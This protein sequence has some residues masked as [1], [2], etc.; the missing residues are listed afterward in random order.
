MRRL[1]IKILPVVMLLTMSSC[2]LFKF[3]VSVGDK[4]MTET[5]FNTR[6]MVRGFYGE[7]T[8]GVISAADSIYKYSDDIDHKINAL[9]WKMQST[10]ACADAAYSGVPEVSLL[11]T[12]VLCCRMQELMQSQPDSLLF[13]R[14]TKIAQTTSGYLLTRIEGVAKRYLSADRFQQ[15]KSFVNTY[16]TSHPMNDLNFVRINLLLDWAENQNTEDKN[17]VKSTGSIPEVMADMNERV[18]GY[19][20]QLSNE[21]AWSKQIFTLGIEQKGIPEKISHKLDSISVSFNRMVLILENS[22][23][24]INAIS[25]DLNIQMQSLISSLNSAVNSAFYNLSGERIAMQEF[26]D[27]QRKE[28]SKEVQQGV[29]IAIRTA[30]EALPALIGKIIIYVIFGLLILLSIPFLIGYM[31]G[32]W[33]ERK[34]NCDG[35]R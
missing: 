26:I 25:G 23:E 7:F 8:K 14:E 34:K 20:S 35:N 10:S 28:L 5:E 29:D 13:G 9:K 4:P 27:Q 19:T 33:R 30:F 2:S 6:A 1:L 15:M 17:Y 16:T 22:P 3:T 21:L 12:W 24:L 11:N 31:L 18:S 32:K